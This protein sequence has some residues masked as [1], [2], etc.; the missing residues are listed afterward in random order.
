M[1]KLFQVSTMGERISIEPL[2]F[3]NHTECWCV[4]RHRSHQHRHNQTTTTTHKSPTVADNYS[5]S[6]N[7]CQC[8]RNFIAVQQRVEASDID[9][10]VVKSNPSCRCDCKSDDVS[11]DLLKKGKIEFSLEDRR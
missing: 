3:I 8:V 1:Q 2:T 4:N 10:E 6:G 11:C 5:Q 7:H 9:D